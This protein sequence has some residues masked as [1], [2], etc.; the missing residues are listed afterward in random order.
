LYPNWLQLSGTSTFQPGTRNSPK[1]ISCRNTHKKPALPKASAAKISPRDMGPSA[2][3]RSAINS[4]APGIGS[5]GSGAATRTKYNQA[6]GT[7]SNTTG[8]PTLNQ[9]KNDTSRD[10]SSADCFTNTILVPVPI[11]QPMPPMLAA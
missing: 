5:P 1:S 8:S 10:S 7:A 6:S 4:F 3:R 9:A 11:L 2:A